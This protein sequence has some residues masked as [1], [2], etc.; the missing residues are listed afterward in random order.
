MNLKENRFFLTA[1]A[2]SLLV[3]LYFFKMNLSVI[4]EGSA[5][6]EIPV[7]FIPDAKRT[8]PEKAIK[9]QKQITVPE[10]KSSAGGYYKSYDR[11]RIVN[12]YLELIK[13]EIDKRKFTPSESAYYGLIGN[14]TIG[15]VITGNGNFTGITVLRSSGDKLLDKT[16]LNAVAA[17]SNAV[18]R[19]AATGSGN[20]SVS[21]TVKYQYGL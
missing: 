11:N 5:G 10:E 3:H 6:V 15:F 16:A 14:V 12:S 18:K 20:L 8:I 19:P 7:T 21:A 9:Q 4:E 13:K 2:I 1:I 17:S